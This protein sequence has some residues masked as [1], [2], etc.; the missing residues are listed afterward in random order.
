MRPNPNPGTGD[1][2]KEQPQK[3]D[4]VEGLVSLILRLPGLEQNR[5]NLF[6]TRPLRASRHQD[7][8]SESELREEI[9][10]AFETHP[11]KDVVE[12]FK[13]WV[14]ADMTMRRTNR[15][16][17]NPW[18]LDPQYAYKT[19]EIL[20]AFLE[21][22]WD[23]WQEEISAVLKVIRP[24][25]TRSEGG[26]P[27]SQDSSLWE[28]WKEQM[29]SWKVWKSLDNQPRPRGKG[30]TLDRPSMEYYNAVADAV[31]AEVLIGYRRLSARQKRY[32]DIQNWLCDASSPPVEGEWLEADE[33]KWEEREIVERMVCQLQEKA[34]SEPL[35]SRVEASR[36]GNII[37]VEVE[38]FLGLCEA[39]GDFSEEEKT[40]MDRACIALEKMPGTHPCED[41]AFSLIGREGFGG[42]VVCT[43]D[44]S[45]TTISFTSHV[46]YESNLILPGGSDSSADTFPIF[47]LDEHQDFSREWE[48]RF[49]FLNAQ[50][51][52]KVNGCVGHE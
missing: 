41:F 1:I 24:V 25:D 52:G 26:S 18:D 42:T 28:Q 19:V 38:E 43:L 37:R 21:H 34:L 51:A 15:S 4:P 12:G 2:P 40:V 36:S 29:R 13:A 10:Q 31:E 32:I 7:R 5:L 22:S 11:D 3:L 45:E 39:S 8:L 50:P 30:P 44:I 16:Q 48:M 9:H 46:W 35:K 20:E 27:F 33:G 47:A 6:F 23:R 14:Q 17:A 49:S